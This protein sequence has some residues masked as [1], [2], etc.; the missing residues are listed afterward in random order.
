MKMGGTW[1]RWSGGKE[2]F[3]WTEPWAFRRL[4]LR[5]DLRAWRRGPLPWLIALFP[6]LV[7]LNLWIRSQRED[8]PV[9]WGTSA[10]LAVTGLFALLGAMALL[11]RLPVCVS[12]RQEFV[13]WANGRAFRRW[14]DLLGFALV[15]RDEF[16][17]LVLVPKNGKPCF[18]GVPR[19]VALAELADF[20]KDRGLEARVDDAGLAAQ[21]PAATK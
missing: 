13:S 16:S 8:Q 7:L 15:R 1:R 17:V 10:L 18:L 14:S 5:A 3:G 4:K 11:V 6:A 20:L 21:F 2:Q 19:E 12:I 9:H